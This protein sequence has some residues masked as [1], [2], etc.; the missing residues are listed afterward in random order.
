MEDRPDRP[1]ASATRA[2]LIC[3]LKEGDRSAWDRLV[4]LYRPLLW[5]WARRAGADAQ[6]FDDVCQEVFVV[7]S[8]RIGAFQLAEREG[9]FRAWLRA[10]TRN[11]CRE[12][13]RTESAQARASGGTDAVIR[14]AEVAEPAAEDDPSEL[15][16]ELYL[17][18]IDGVRSDF[19]SRDWRVFER[20]TYD[21][22]STAEIAVE[23]GLSAVNVRTIKSRI[24]RRLR[25]EL[26]E[27][28]TPPSPAGDS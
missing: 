1:P 27:L 25:E 16:A 22:R 12:R 19:S 6:D 5:H 28:I 2:S 18:A 8:R 11:V 24:Y 23:T 14:L 4:S 15:V 21:G 9:S 13:G 17:R 3:L 7:V 26:G 20:L 10:I